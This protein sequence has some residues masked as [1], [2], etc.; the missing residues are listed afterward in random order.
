MCISGRGLNAPTKGGPRSSLESVAFERLPGGPPRVL[1]AACLPSNARFHYG[2]RTCLASPLL[3]LLRVTIDRQTQA[4]LSPQL[5]AHARL[6]IPA[7]LILAMEV[8]VEI[9]GV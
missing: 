5:I 1:L 4:T 8:H 2:P 7:G 6:F 3:R 9:D